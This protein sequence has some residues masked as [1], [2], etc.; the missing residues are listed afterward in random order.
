MPYI[1]AE[2]FTSPILKKIA[3]GDESIFRDV[4]ENDFN[5]T[6]QVNYNYRQWS[7]LSLA[8]NNGHNHL[9]KRLLEVPAIVDAAA[10]N[11]N[12]LLWAAEDGHLGVVNRLLEIPAVVANAIA[13]YNHALGLAAE[14]GHIHVVNRLLEVPAV[15][16]SAAACNNHALFRAAENG[17]IHVVNRLLEIPAVA[18]N[19][20]ASN[21]KA[22][23]FAVE[24]GHLHVVNI[25]LEIPAVVAKTTDYN[26]SVLLCAVENGHL[27]IV[28]RLLEIPMVAGNGAD[29]NDLALCLAEE[30]DYFE[31]SHILAKLQWP[32]G[33]IDMPDY[34]HHCLPAIH[35][36][37]LLASGKKE[38]EDMVKCW[39]RGNPAN[40]T[41]DIHFPGHNESSQEHVLIDRYNAPRLILQYAGC[42]DVARESGN[43]SR[44][45]HGMNS[46][47]YSSRLHKTFQT[48]YE[49]GQRESRERLGYGDGAVVV[50][51]PGRPKPGM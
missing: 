21:N 50:Y 34:L 16:D 7:P 5:L 3:D 38:F 29:C 2:E 6:E 47:L 19:A 15:A 1:S 48:A 33:V 46:L 18:D 23:R 44:A 43:E 30:N 42:I 8:C 27:S 49:N 17:H 22:L 28:N 9:V 39:I 36:G 20:A 10:R 40:N 35:Q 45:D 4:S 37:A 13:D 32:R 24:N 31:I 26:N 25:L 51:N 12:A 41:S 11:N 14:N